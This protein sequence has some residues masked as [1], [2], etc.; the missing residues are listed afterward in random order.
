MLDSYSVRWRAAE[1]RVDWQL[2]YMLDSY[3]VRWRAGQPR[4]GL[5]GSD[6]T[7]LAVTHVEAGCTEQEDVVVDGKTGDEATTG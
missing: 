5:I 3:S 1:A 6:Y 4:L 7:C 2:L